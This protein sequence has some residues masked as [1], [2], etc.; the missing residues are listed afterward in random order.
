LAL[1]GLGMMLLLAQALEVQ[2]LPMAVYVGVTMA[3]VSAFLALGF[4]MGSLTS[5]YVLLGLFYAGLI[6]AAVGNIPT[7]LN[8]L[9]ILRHLRIAL[10]GHIRE[11]GPIVQEIGL[12]F[13]IA[14]GLL[15]TAMLIFSRKEFIGKRADEG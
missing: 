14:V 2:L 3:G 5:R 1:G 4:L 12:V 13:L 15:A 11:S 9:S 7:Q 6:E 10:S 8:N